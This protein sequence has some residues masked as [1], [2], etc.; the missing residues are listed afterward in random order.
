MPPQMIAKTIS[1]F[2]FSLSK[3]G[4]VDDV[5]YEITHCNFI[6]LPKYLLSDIEPVVYGVASILWFKA[7]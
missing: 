3:E 7:N 6:Q 5:D 2:E 1:F 4:L